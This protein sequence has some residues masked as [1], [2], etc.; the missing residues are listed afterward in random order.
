[1]LLE[2]S[3]DKLLLTTTDEVSHT[4]SIAEATA[5]IA[6]SFARAAEPP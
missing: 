4:L 1:V 2:Q 5:A 3:E 6:W